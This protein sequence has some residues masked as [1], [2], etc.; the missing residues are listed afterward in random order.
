MIWTLFLHLEN[1]W[2][3]PLSTESWANKQKKKQNEEK[4][5]KM[6]AYDKGW[7][8]FTIFARELWTF[9]LTPDLFCKAEKPLGASVRNSCLLSTCL[10]DAGKGLVMYPEEPGGAWRVCW[11]PPGCLLNTCTF[12][13]YILLVTLSPFSSFSFIY[14]D[15]GNASSWVKSYSRISA[16][17]HSLWCWRNFEVP[18]IEWELSPSSSPSTYALDL[19][20]S[21]FHFHSSLDASVSL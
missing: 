7:N 15:S 5:K 2:E 14:L 9:P 4:E 17:D 1:Y 20:S 12:P 10:W 6:Y 3:W 11:T 8:Y 18:L 13:F 19:Y 21:V 16:K